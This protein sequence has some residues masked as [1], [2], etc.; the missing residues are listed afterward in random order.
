M[1]KK[2]FGHSF[3]YSLANHVPLFANILILPFITPFL[4]KEDYGIFGLTYAYIGAFNAFSMLGVEA[5][6]QN[7]YFKNKSKFKALWSKYFGLLSI[8][9]LMYSAIITTLMYF[10]F[11]QKVNENIYVFLLIIIIPILCFDLT[12]TFGI[13]FCQ[14]EGKH[15]NVYFS[16][17]IASFF[18]IASSFI[19]I[20]HFKL[21]YLGFL[22]ASAVASCT[23]FLFF[24]YIIHYKLRIFPD[25][26]ISFLFIKKTLKISSPVILHN[27]SGY[28]LNSSD[29]IVLDLNRISINEIGGYNLAYSFSNYFSSFNNSMNS[30]LTPIYFKCFALNDKIKSSLLVNSITILWFYFI[31]ISCL[32]ICIWCKEIFGFLFRN[33]EFID[34]Y[35]FVP[36][37]LVGMMYRPFYVACVDKNIFFE[38]TKNILLISVGGGMLNIL[39]NLLLVPYFGIQSV[40]YTTFVSYLYMGFSGFYIKSIKEDLDFKGNPMIFI[41]III[42]TLIISLILM[43]LTLYLKIIISIL[44]LFVSLL[45]YNYRF[46]TMVNRLIKENLF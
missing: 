14:Y 7:A 19:C 15:Q 34:V 10:I 45:I 35:T 24:F 46:K 17:F 1:I 4:T 5:L 40:L 30:I 29:R 3:L 38:K 37:I 11:Y 6:I 27:Y 25:V 32:L 31:L 23:Q 13:K 41:F 36:Y 42:S 9:R 44:I 2:I 33:P 8:W 43:D 20:Y 16:S 21:G 12:K 22:I 39:L 28:L 26:R 18:S